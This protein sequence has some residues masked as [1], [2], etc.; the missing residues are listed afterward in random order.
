MSIIHLDLILD[1]SCN[2]P[3]IK[4]PFFFKFYFQNSVCVLYTV[5]KIHSHISDTPQFLCLPV[6]GGGVS[7]PPII[8]SYQ[9]FCIFALIGWLM[10]TSS[11]CSMQVSPPG[12]MA[13]LLFEILVFVNFR[14]VLNYN[15]TSYCLIRNMLRKNIKVE[16]Y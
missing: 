9:S 5:K 8:H 6:G 1:N 16:A 7:W 2:I 3:C 13:T 12:I 10:A 11:G 15:W 4:L 14:E